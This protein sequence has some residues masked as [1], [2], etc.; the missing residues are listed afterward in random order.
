MIYLTLRFLISGFGR[1]WDSD[2]IGEAIPESI[3]PFDSGQAE[4]THIILSL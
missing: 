4:I 3:D 2:V 1:F